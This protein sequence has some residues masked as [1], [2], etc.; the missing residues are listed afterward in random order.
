M[1]R[2]EYMI[3]HSKYFPLDI[4]SPYRIYGLIAKYGYFYIKITKDMYGLKQAAIISYTSQILTSS[5]QKFIMGP[6]TR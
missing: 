1:S 4:K 2:A 3:I 6:K 5:I